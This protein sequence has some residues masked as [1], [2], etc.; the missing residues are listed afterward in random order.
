MENIIYHYA[1]IR[2]YLL[3]LLPG[4]HKKFW[5]Q[6][7]EYVFRDNCYVGKTN[8]AIPKGKE[9][10]LDEIVTADLIK[11]ED[12]K[13]LQS[14]LR[15]LLKKY[16]SGRYFTGPIEGT[17][18]ICSLIEEMETTLFNHN[19]CVRCGIFEF[20]DNKMRNLIDW[21]KIEVQY[22]NSDYLSVEFTVHLNED[23]SNELIELINMNYSEK[24][25]Y[26]H[27]SLTAKHNRTG[28][29][30]NYTVAHYN[31]DLLKADKIYEFTSN[32]V[33]NLYNSLHRY[34]PFVL[35]NK[36]IMPPRI[37]VYSTNIDYHENTQNFWESIGIYSYNGQF[38]DE[39]QK[40]FFICNYSSR[41]EEDTPENRIMLIYKESNK[42]PYDVLS[43]K[44]LVNMHI[45]FIGTDYFMLLFLK[46]ISKE[47]GRI[48]AKYN[49]K[50]DKMKIKKKNLKRL[51]KTQYKFSREYD[52]YNRFIK[53]T[54]WENC[55]NNLRNEFCDNDAL[56]KEHNLS[57][58]TSYKYLFESAVKRKK[59]VV[60]ECTALNAEFN[61][62]R[63]I[64]QNLYDF[65]NASKNRRLNIMMF[66]VAVITL[67]LVIFPERAQWLSYIL[68]SC[69]HFI[70]HLFI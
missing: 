12:L 35:H 14:G 36:G 13:K 67:A 42:K 18:K 32:I 5:K 44:S 46:I 66:V 20:R 15:C 49:H 8:N 53:N 45:D 58:Y 40:A 61:D 41:Y 57:P 64:L 43:V 62:K 33:W 6:N 24:R 9:L 16:R 17:E 51:I 10:F 38:I 28:A 4:K 23:M 25:G 21:F 52:N 60:K 68:K 27:G 30:K 63:R 2:A 47:S 59:R 70:L 48:I 29:F 1:R 56:I 37:E 19:N 65:K 39:H 11:R 54:N 69:Y 7:Y 3:S 55:L 26:A 31:N 22:M 50:V 34:I